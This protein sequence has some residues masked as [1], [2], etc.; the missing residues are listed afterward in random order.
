MR[1]LALLI[2]IAAASLLLGASPAAHAANT[3][4]DQ[5]TFADSFTDPDFC[6][7]GQDVDV[8]VS[9]HG[10]FFPTPNKPGVDFAQ[11]TIVTEIY[12]N[13]ETG[14]TVIGHTSHRFNTG[15]ISGDPAGIHVDEDSNIGVMQFRVKHGEVLIM[16][17]G[18]ITVT[19]TWNGEE[20]L[21]GEITV[22]NG[23]HPSFEDDELFCQAVTPALGL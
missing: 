17:A 22:N 16:N 19:S 10:T 13:P 12:S 21:S 6:G 1:H 23:P 11:V 5:F 15:T 14:A 9:A 18:V 2:G 20:F 8:T 3:N 7:T 4:N